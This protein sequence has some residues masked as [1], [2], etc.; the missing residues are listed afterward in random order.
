MNSSF[1][2][3]IEVGDSMDLDHL[4]KGARQFAYQLR[5]FFPEEEAPVSHYV[6]ENHVVVL[7][8]KK[9]YV[10]Y[11]NQFIDY[12]GDYLKNVEVV[13]RDAEKVC[14]VNVKGRVFLLEFQEEKDYLSF[15]KYY[16]KYLE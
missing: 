11:Y 15:A 4:K 8:T 12:V 7:S 10:Y 5:K 1:F 14:E 3:K 2:L 9:L 13:C 6:C 16:Q